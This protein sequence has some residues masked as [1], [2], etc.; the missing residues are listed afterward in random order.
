MKKF[1]T[2]LTVLALVFSCASFTYAKGKKV[3][4]EEPAAEMEMDEENYDEEN[5]EE[6]GEEE[7]EEEVKEKS[8]LDI[9]LEI[10]AGV[11]AVKTNDAGEIVSLISIGE[12]PY[13]KL[14]RSGKDR[15]RAR[16]QAMLDCDARFVEW[17]KSNL[18]VESSSEGETIITF[19]GNKSS[20]EVTEEGEKS[21]DAS[22]AEG[23]SSQIDKRK[24]TS[25]AKGCVRGMQMLTAQLVERDGDKF[26]IVVKGLKAQNISAVKKLTRELN[27][28]ED[29]V[30]ESPKSSKIRKLGNGAIAPDAADF[31]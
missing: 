3:V 14:F 27:S 5:Y 6:E 7:E 21:E 24:I 8:P 10:G 2:L 30:E 1:F 13:V 20:G 15:E 28:D 23:V 31:F 18:T 4:K 11:H 19:K 25:Y 12:A 22:S 29:D 17:A 16:N 9:Y 26:F